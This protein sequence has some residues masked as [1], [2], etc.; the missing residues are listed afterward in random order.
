MQPKIFITGG[1]GLLGINWALES[2]KK[3]IIA[4]NQHKRKLTLPNIDSFTV[5]L[6]DKTSIVACF[7]QWQP[8]L[9]VHT[10]GMA[11]VEACEKDPQL[12]RFIN[13]ELASNIAEIAYAQGIK[14]IHISTDQLFDG[15]QAFLSEE[16]APCPLNAY[17][18]SKAYG[19]ECVLKNNPDALIL[20]CNFYGWGTDYRHSFSDF[21]YHNLKAGKPI[22]LF[23][24]V[25][26][27]PATS[28]QLIKKAHALVEQNAKGIFNMV[29]AEKLSKYDFG[30]QLAQAFDL[31]ERLITACSIDE[32]GLLAKRPKDMSLSDKKVSSLLKQ[33]LGSV[34]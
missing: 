31:D 2:S 10:A 13:A 28:H 21:I 14:L 8:A 30:L 16:A 18:V 34:V 27:T 6:E 23:N 32:A 4:I 29:G 26:Y 9:I 24:D 11:N 22:K 19:E 17:G 25:F 33:G 12:A 15:T 3:Y 20:R 5:D 1:T 7:E